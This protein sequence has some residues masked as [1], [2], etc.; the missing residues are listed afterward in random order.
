[1]NLILLVSLMN[2]L[3]KFISNFKLNNLSHIYINI[4]LY[5]YI[6]HN[7]NHIKFIKIK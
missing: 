4:Y 5:Y 3:Y 6:L 2:L 7:I 1:M